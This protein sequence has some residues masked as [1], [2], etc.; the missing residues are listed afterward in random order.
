MK[1]NTVNDDIVVIDDI[2]YLFNFCKDYVERYCID[3]D[4]EDIKNIHPVVW[5]DVL[6][7]I[8][9]NIIK[10]NIMLLKV[11]NN[12]NNQYDRDNILYLFDN[13]Y[14]K[15]CNHYTQE[16]SQYGFLLLS[17]MD[18]QSIYNISKDT[19]SEKGFDFSEKIMQDNENSLWGL[20]LGDKGNPNKY[21]GKLN[22][23]HGWNG[24]GTTSQATNKATLSIEDIR[25]QVKEL[26]QNQAQFIDSAVV[27]NDE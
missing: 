15:L 21:F 9:N 23:Y 12:K 4:I 6:F 25:E 5:N 8:N 17:G 20:M 2:S 16:V 18:K 11:K 22:R 13:V 27:D 19:L 10:P 14:R 7:E 26:S 24:A 3:N 1:N